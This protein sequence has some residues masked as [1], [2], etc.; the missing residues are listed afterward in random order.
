M[1]WIAAGGH[2]LLTGARPVGQPGRA[3]LL[4]SV[5]ARARQRVRVNGRLA[6]RGG[7]HQGRPLHDAR[8]TAGTLLGEQHVDMHVTQRILGHAQ[9]T[10]TRI[11][12]DRRTR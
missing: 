12:T 2:L 9:V 8:H 4:P 11:D 10:T 3:V 6:R 1:I 5:V 7:H